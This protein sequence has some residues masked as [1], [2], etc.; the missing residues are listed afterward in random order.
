VE[1]VEVVQGSAV[2][3]AGPMLQ[4]VKMQPSEVRILRLK[5]GKA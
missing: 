4:K 5:R 3:A 1:V 2:E